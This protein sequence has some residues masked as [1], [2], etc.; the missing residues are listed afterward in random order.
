M[1]H[2]YILGILNLQPYNN[3]IYNHITMTSTDNYI[4]CSE[5]FQALA[6]STMGKSLTKLIYIL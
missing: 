2:N 1:G 3:E 4:H 5:I 6:L